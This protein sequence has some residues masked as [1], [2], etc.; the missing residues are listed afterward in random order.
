MVHSGDFL[1]PSLVGNY[2][3]PDTKEHD[4]GQ[5]MVKLLNASGS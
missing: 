4:Y 2:E 5:T 1:S 3:D